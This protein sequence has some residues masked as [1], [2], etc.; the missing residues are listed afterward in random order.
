LL[1]WGAQDCMVAPA[2]AE[3]LLQDL[4]SDAK[5]LHLQEGAGH[6]MPYQQPEFIANEIEAFVDGL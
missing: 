4:G 6:F 2:V 5:A 3:Q 1:L